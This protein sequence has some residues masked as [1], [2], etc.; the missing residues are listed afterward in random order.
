[1][2]E[3]CRDKSAA[4]K[5]KLEDYRKGGGRTLGY[6]C[7]AFPDSVAAG[8]GMRPVRVLSLP[9]QAA[10]PVRPDVCPL[11]GA[12][13]SALLS[14]S[15]LP[16]QIDVW[17]GLFTCD[18]TR[19]MFQELAGY[20]GVRLFQVHVPATRTEAS[21]K[22]FSSQMERLAADM[23]A[24]GLSEGYDAAR[25]LEWEKA[26]RKAAAVLRDLNL[27]SVLSPLELHCML[28]T[29]HIAEPSSLLG[30]ARTMQ[31]RAVYLPRVKVG[32]IGCPE[33]ME[34]DLVPA[35]LEA[36]GAGAVY[37]NCMAPWSPSEQPLSGLVA[38]LAAQS[39]R[40]LSC[41][42]CRPDDGMVER[43]LADIGASRVDGAIL[44]T[45]KFCDLWFTQKE[46]LRSILP[47]PV[48]V[49]DTTGGAGEEER[50][51]TRVEAFVE[52]LS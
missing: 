2:R 21:E 27:S 1:M 34:D 12:L 26:R 38:E 40:N 19:R 45:Q 31:G 37:M 28:N 43:I 22:Y 52:S 41:A 39:F 30:L 10:I 4:E 24:S 23:V 33:A 7:S 13:L 36:L 50:V 14:R 17:A 18:Q 3:C 32:I 16:A 47:V 35:S 25:A 8:L 6:L 5:R 15:G 29:A 49:L 42:R 11:T 51:R 20:T 44:K 46:R 9:P 48:L